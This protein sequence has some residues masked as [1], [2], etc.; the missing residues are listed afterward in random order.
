MIKHEHEFLSESGNE[1]EILTPDPVYKLKR[2]DILVLFG[3]DSKIE[4]FR[5]FSNS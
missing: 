5:K 1:P 4:E 2:N 3:K